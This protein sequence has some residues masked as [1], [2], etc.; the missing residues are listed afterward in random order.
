MSHPADHGPLSADGPDHPT[1]PEAEAPAG[2][3]DTAVGAVGADT[4]LVAPH[5]LRALAC[6]VD[7]GFVAAAV[8]VV[9]AVDLVLFV[10]VL[11]LVYATYSGVL[12]WLTGGRTVGKALCGLVVRRVGPPVGPNARGLAWCLGR[13]LGLF[14]VDVMG[15]GTL[16][17]FINRR[18]RCLHDFV[19]G[20]EV[21]RMPEAELLA[22]AR[23]RLA[24][25]DEAYGAAR[26]AALRKAGVPSRIWHAS[27]R[28]AGSYAAYVGWAALHGEVPAG[29]GTAVRWAHAAADAA[30]TV[31]RRVRDM[32][33]GGADIPVAS[34]P[35]PSSWSP[36]AVAGTVAVTLPAS[37]VT[38]TVISETMRP[39]VSAPFTVTGPGNH[40]GLELAVDGRGR[41]FV[42]WQD[43]TVDPKAS[44][45]RHQIDEDWS[46]A[47]NLSEGFANPGTAVLRARPNGQMCA[48]FDGFPAN[49]E[50]VT[51]YGLYQRCWEGD[52]W[53]EPEQVTS[54]DGE[55]TDF[56]SGWAPA[57]SPDGMLHTAWRTPPS[58]LGVGRQELSGAGI[59][60]FPQ[61]VIDSASR[62]HLVW[63]N[64]ETGNWV[65]RW[66]EDAGETWSPVETILD[67]F[68][69]FDIASDRQGGIHALAALGVEAVHRR[70]TAAGGWTSQLD[71]SGDE[72][73]YLTSLGLAGL[74]DGGAAIAW[75]SN[76]LV[77]SERSSDGILADMVPVAAAAGVSVV[78][79]EI[80]ADG[81]HLHLTWLTDEGAVV[82]VQLR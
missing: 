13:G 80:A 74:P 30:T 28:I 51:T 19:F 37:L 34:L 32:L 48:F 3:A 5:R 7:L 23:E 10:L 43:L 1:V 22:T 26:E 18:H 40:G 41:A 2:E 17:T 16:T 56:T 52:A 25:L 39:D 64:G 54:I 60:D 68:A 14:F 31:G 38:G 77:V 29:A 57:F 81:D 67:S 71:M 42:A 69:A 79:A 75:A 55:F 24:A 49:T 15:F 27:T 12:T 45:V 62:F 35:A 21:V 46:D 6:A 20:S 70:W 44:T 61:F 66:S 47:V 9:A 8:G 58:D 36:A 53:S 82:H 50:W 65:H 59:D 72:D 63:W 78:E 33:G 11:P 76:S 4:A 73:N